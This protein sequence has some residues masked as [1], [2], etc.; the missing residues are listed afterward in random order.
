M[1]QWSPDKEVKRAVEK[2]TTGAY[3][4][5]RKKSSYGGVEDVRRGIIRTSTQSVFARGA[6]PAGGGEAIWY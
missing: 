1:Y 2:C 6:K 5:V 4:M 3:F